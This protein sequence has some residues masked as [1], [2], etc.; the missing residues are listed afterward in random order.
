[1]WLALWMED[2]RYR[3]LLTPT[4]IKRL[5]HRPFYGDVFGW[6]FQKWDGPMDYWTVTT[7]TDG[8]GINGGLSRRSGDNA[9]IMNTIDVP[10]ADDYLDRITSAGGKV[11]MPKDAVPGVGWFAAFVDPE[12]NHFGIMQ[13]DSEATST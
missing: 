7:G 2:R 5:E 4:R 8:I 9:T 6:T 12:G 1:M 10:S 13:P 3:F 11:V